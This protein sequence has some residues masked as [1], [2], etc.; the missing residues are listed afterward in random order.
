VC[1][2]THSGAYQTQTLFG[3]GTLLRSLPNLANPGTT[4]SLD[5]WL[6]I[7]H[8]LLPTLSAKIKRWIPSTTLWCDEV[9]QVLTAQQVT[10]WSVVEVGSDLL[11]FLA[12]A[13]P[14][15]GVGSSAFGIRGHDASALLIVIQWVSA[16]AGASWHLVYG[17]ASSNQTLG[18]LAGLGGGGTDNSLAGVVGPLADGCW[19][20]GS[21]VLCCAGQGTIFEVPVSGEELLIGTTVILSVCPSAASVNLLGLLSPTASSNNIND[22]SISLDV[23]LFDQSVVEL[24]N[25]ASW[26]LSGSLTREE[27]IEVSWSVSGNEIFITSSHL[28][29][30]K[31]EVLDGS[32]SHDSFN[33]VILQGA[34]WCGCCHSNG[35]LAVGS[36]H[37]IGEGQAAEGVAHW[38]T[39]FVWVVNNIWVIVGVEV[40][41]TLLDAFEVSA[42][43][44][45]CWFVLLTS[46]LVEDS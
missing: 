4:P 16:S 39:R 10:F 29:S 31:V 43:P 25:I 13:H 21:G 8:E 44:Q 12:S 42:I 26:D 41:V 17:C 24:S 18:S 46:I 45:T 2:K 1:P 11:G 33:I 20:G 22:E 9:S 14:L 27:V 6:T 35:G 38:T 28:S 23:P 37:D 19:F 40:V 5:D 7:D 15:C 32:V 36:G 30:S 34:D 3:C